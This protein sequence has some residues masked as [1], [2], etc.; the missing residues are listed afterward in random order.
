MKTLF[1]LL[2]IALFA[3]PALFGQQMS[4]P[5]I[6]AKGFDELKRNGSLAAM[7][8][9]LAGSS[10][11]LDQD[12]EVATGRLNH[13]QE[14]RGRMIGHEI[15]RIVPLSPSTERVYAV[16]KFEKGIAWMSFDCYRT[17][18]DW[19]IDR[20]DFSTNANQILPPNVLGGQ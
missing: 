19:I 20:F 11:E 15:V 9:W 5:P 3:S 1:S 16:V 8:V 10:R 18:A 12:Q 14:R 7:A 13:I 17:D 6:V 4:V 2:F